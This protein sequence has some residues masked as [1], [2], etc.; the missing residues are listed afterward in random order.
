MIERIREEVGCKDAKVYA[1][2]GLSSLI[3]P[4]CKNSITTLENLTLEGLINIYELN[5]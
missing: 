3:V 2:G 4:L 1:T 5:R